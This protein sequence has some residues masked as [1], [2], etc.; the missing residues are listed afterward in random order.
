MNE[1]TELIEVGVEGNKR[2]IIS[3]IE[4]KKELGNLL[5]G[6]HGSNDF[7]LSREIA[8]LMNNNKEWSRGTTARTPYGTQKCWKRITK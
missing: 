1:D 8:D 7:V 5:V 2:K 4:I 6:N 3:I